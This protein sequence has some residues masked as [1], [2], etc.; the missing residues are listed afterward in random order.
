MEGRRK[1]GGWQAHCGE[2]CTGTDGVLL[3]FDYIIKQVS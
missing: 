1:S 2:M 3:R